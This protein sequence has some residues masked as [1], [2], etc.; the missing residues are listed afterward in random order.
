MLSLVQLTLLVAHF[1]A[2]GL[3]DGAGGGTRMAIAYFMMN[4]AER[5]WT[6]FAG[7]HL[8][9]TQVTVRDAIKGA[10]KSAGPAVGQAMGSTLPGVLILLY[11]NDEEEA[12]LVTGMI[13]ACIWN[14][15]WASM[16]YAKEVLHLENLAGSESIKRARDLGSVRSGR[17][18]GFVL[19]LGGIRLV[20]LLCVGLGIDTIVS[21]LFQLTVEHPAFSEFTL[22]CGWLC[23]GPFVATVRLF[24]Y[25]D[26]RT[27]R[28]GW[29][30]Q[31]RFS[32]IVERAEQERARSLVL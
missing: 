11:F 24:D 31:V 32:A 17:S 12:F 27:R 29:D 13:L 20:F 4:L 18:M 19:I 16:F 10:M 23:A 21:A 26:A 15:G 22:T 7:R 6:V 5:V 3:P 9:R 30:I 25:I 2:F 1:L 14:F 8:F 28:E